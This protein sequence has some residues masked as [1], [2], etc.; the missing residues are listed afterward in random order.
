MLKLSVGLEV[1]KK[2]I[3]ERQIQEDRK[4]DNL[5]IAIK[6]FNTYEK[7]TEPVLDY[8]KQSNLLKI[9]NG[10]ATIDEINVEI[11]GLIE[12]FKGWL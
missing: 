8:Y 11:S 10:E 5:E 6:R 2:R 3:L 12:R 7:S 1:I 4:D 9:I